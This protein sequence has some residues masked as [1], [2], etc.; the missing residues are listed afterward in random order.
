MLLLS[1]VCPPSPAIRPVIA[2]VTRWKPIGDALAPTYPSLLPADLYNCLIVRG[3][4]RCLVQPPVSRQGRRGACVSYG[5]LPETV[6]D[7]AHCC[8][9]CCYCCC[10]SAAPPLPALL[11]YCRSGRRRRRRG[12][13]LG[14]SRVILLHHSYTVNRICC[15]VQFQ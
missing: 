5:T 9:R 3:G 8:C 4:W 10:C 12:G 15:W 2:E 6:P 13:S 1:G 14:S 11:Y 7:S